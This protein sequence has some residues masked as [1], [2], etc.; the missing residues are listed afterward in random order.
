MDTPVKHQGAAEYW[1]ADGSG[2]PDGSQFN[3]LF[4]PRQI[5]ECMTP[6]FVNGFE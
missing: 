5:H 3:V 6:L 1:R 2:M 4:S